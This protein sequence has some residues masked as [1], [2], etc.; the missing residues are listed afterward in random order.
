M[1]MHAKKHKHTN[2]HAHN[3][4]FQQI[5]EMQ[6]YIY[7]YFLVQEGARGV[8]D[9]LLI[10]FYHIRTKPYA[11]QL[12]ISHYK[13]TGHRWSSER[14]SPHTTIINTVAPHRKNI[15]NKQHY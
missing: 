2:T 3:A 9:H 11:G 8:L 14:K 1:Y 15:E 10:K 5:T 4:T 6:P 13:R 7:V 12:V